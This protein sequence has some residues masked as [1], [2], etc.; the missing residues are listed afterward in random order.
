MK[1]PDFVKELHPT[2]KK[3]SE[4][5]AALLKESI[6]L[7]LAEGRKEVKFRVEKPPSGL[8]SSRGHGATRGGAV[9]KRGG[10]INIGSSPMGFWSGSGPSFSRGGGTTM[11][12][13][14]PPPSG[15]PSFSSY[16]SYGGNRYDSPLN[17][18]SCYNMPFNSSYDSQ[19]Y[20]SY[21]RSPSFGQG[22]PERQPSFFGSR[23]SGP[24]PQIETPEDFDVSLKNSISSGLANALGDLTK[25][26]KNDDDASVALQVSNALTQALL[27]YRMDDIK[28]GL[29]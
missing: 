19:N 12:S 26:V 9:R 4:L 28:Q 29:K 20:D 14:V 24:P 22:C 2:S 17:D 27:K 15:P 11:G 23:Y 16:G 10:K 3:R 5:T 13:Y 8:Q 6:D 21:Q 18:P 25:L 1:R 7:E